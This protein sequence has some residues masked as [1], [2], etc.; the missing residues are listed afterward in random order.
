MFFIII[1]L[2]FTG[3]ACK[4]LNEWEQAIFKLHEGLELKRIIYQGEKAKPEVALACFLLAE[5]LF[6]NKEPEKAL[7]Y[8]QEALEIHKA[9][10]AAED[11]VE[12]LLH[13]TLC[14]KALKKI[15]DAKGSLKK[16]E[17]LCV[18][19]SLHDE[20]QL[21]IHK[22]MADIFVEEEYE[23]RSKGLYHLKE[24]EAILRRIKQSEEDEVTLL[25]L[26]AKIVSLDLIQTCK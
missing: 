26:Q 1:I 12:C 14:Y 7:P 16:L 8:F 5:A 19:K 18:S 4:L 24:A 13:I 22:E 23:D 9:N 2:S 10:Q 15:D 21:K 25:E 17:K 11:E 6:Q 3:Y 20:M